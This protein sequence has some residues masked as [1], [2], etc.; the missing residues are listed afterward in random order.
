MSALLDLAVSI[1][2]EAGAIQRERRNEPRI[3]ETKSSAIDLVTDVDEASER[4]ILERIEAA[5]PDDGILAEEAGTREGRNGY[6]WVI[7]PL[8]GT[9]NYAHGIPHFAVSIGIELDG[10]RE[11]G[12]VY[13]PIKDELFSAQRGGGAFLNGE[14]IG[15]STTQELERALLATGFAYNVHS[16][17]VDNVEY[18]TRFIK[19]AQAVRRAGSAALDLAYLACGRFD[20]FWELD[21][22]AWD[23]AAGY[24]L[25]EEAG[26]VV[27]NLAGGPAPRSGAE[28]VGSNG[29]LHPALLAVIA[30]SG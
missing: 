3:I 14:R 1:A 9:T 17:E 25:V 22:H 20:G 10:T 30:A 5:R 19:R 6:V 12:V 11:V 23:V 26:G 29:R 15:V 16:A 18:F 8:D 28:I 21:L 13:D 27:S 4:L 2:R 24:L 7:D